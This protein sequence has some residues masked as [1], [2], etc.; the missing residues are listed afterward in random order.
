MSGNDYLKYIT[1]EVVAYLDMTREEKKESK[2][3]RKSE[4]QK[5]SNQWF[6]ILPMS[7]KLFMKKD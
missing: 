4:N 1:E 6:G 2:E 5:L 3:Q 7:L